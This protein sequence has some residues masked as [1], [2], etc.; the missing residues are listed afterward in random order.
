[1]VVIAIIAILASML[2][3]AL[4]KA[5]EKAR[6]ISCLSNMKTL[7]TGWLSYSDEHNGEL[8]NVN[9]RK[10][11]AQRFVTI[12]ADA[13]LPWTYMLSTFVGIANF[14][15]GAWDLLPAAIRSKGPYI[16]PSHPHVMDYSSYPHY[17]LPLYNI[18][19]ENYGGYIAVA[20]IGKIRKPVLQVIFADRKKAD[21]TLQLNN[22]G[23]TLEEKD[24]ELRHGGSFN[25]A[26]ADGHA[27][28]L[29]R[30]EAT[31]SS[32]TEALKSDAWGWQG[33]Y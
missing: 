24:L 1:M 18:G 31:N 14:P 23:S 12:P 33:I 15:T 11:R 30:G 6:Q 32:A 10:N 9:N 17:A 13:S 22:S 5:R 26:Y 8:L 28:S 7:A 4:S 27:G 2:L 21:G 3:P 25:A 19:G 16:C 20:S 29:K